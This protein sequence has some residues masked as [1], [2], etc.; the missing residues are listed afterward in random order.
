MLSEYFDYIAIPAIHNMLYL[1][2]ILHVTV[3]P[4]NIFKAIS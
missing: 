1:D 2:I 3:L 4:V